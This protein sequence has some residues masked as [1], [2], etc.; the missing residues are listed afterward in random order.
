MEN[1]LTESLPTRMR[2]LRASR[3]CF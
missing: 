2:V 1:K 3:Q